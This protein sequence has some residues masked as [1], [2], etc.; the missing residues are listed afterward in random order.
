MILKDAG[1]ELAYT[2]GMSPVGL[3]N[4]W[5]LL[6]DGVTTLLTLANAATQTIDASTAGVFLI[7]LTQ[8]T[9]FAF[10]NFQVGQTIVLV[11]TQDGTG[12]RTG[13][14]PSGSIFAG[15]S[16]TLTTTDAAVDSV[17]VTCT[18]VGAYLCSLLKAYA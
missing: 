8:N 3:G 12:S 6:P 5:G 11:L 18:A 15:G 14:F 17:S 13:T 7:T 10:T 2:Q 4:K 1:A 16:K 9:T